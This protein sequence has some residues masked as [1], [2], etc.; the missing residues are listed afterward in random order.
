[1]TRATKIIEVIASIIVIIILFYVAFI[2]LQKLSGQSP[3][4]E[5]ILLLATAAIVV[6]IF[7][8]EY[9]LGEVNEFKK[10]VLEDLKEIKENVKK[11]KSH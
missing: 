9:K 1:M 5:E 10:N 8:I 6:E 4:V 7:R 2:V 11:R 3:S